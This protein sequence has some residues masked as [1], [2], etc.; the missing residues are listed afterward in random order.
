MT[1]LCGD[2]DLSMEVLGRICQTS[3]KDFGDI[4]EYVS[5]E[6]EEPEL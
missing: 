6:R 2:K 1:K 5:K 3:N 4:M